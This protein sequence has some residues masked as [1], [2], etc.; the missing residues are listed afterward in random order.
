MVSLERQGSKSSAT[1][2]CLA[3]I[4]VSLGTGNMTQV[5]SVAS[6]LEALGVDRYICGLAAALVFG[7]V[8]LAGKRAI[9]AANSVLVPL[10]CAVYLLSLLPVL[11]GNIGRMG[12]VLCE[13]FGS[14]FGIDAM[15]GGFTAY[16]FSRAVREG[17]SRGVFSNES[18]MGSAPLAY[19]ASDAADA[20]AQSR[21]GIAEIF[22]DT[23]IISTLTALCLLC[24]G[25]DSISE[26]MLCCY[27]RVGETALAVMLCVFALASMLCWHYYASVCI[28][29]IP[30]GDIP[31][32]VYPW[33]SVIAAFLG[34]VI[35]QSTVWAIADIF[36]L[37]MVLPNLYMLFLKVRKV[38]GDKSD[39]RSL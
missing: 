33:L 23:Y 32:R 11:T 36:N 14:A 24:G 27:G 35:P 10:C 18:G 34:A 2:F 17:I 31:G 22:T 6:S 25:F 37:L 39:I 19:C 16:A 7:L 26:M 20:E 1:V 30:H 21:L 28:D 5:G 13:I 38:N 9:L 12:D 4:F 29:F 3:A 8:V 15:T